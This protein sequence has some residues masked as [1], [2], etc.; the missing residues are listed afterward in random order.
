MVDATYQAK[1][2]MTDGGDKQVIASGGELDVESGG[3]FKIA[4]TAVTAS[5]AELNGDSAKVT[6]FTMAAASAAAN[7]SEVTITAKDAAGATLAGVHNFDLW[8]SDAATGA[9]LTGTAASGTVTAKSAS[10]EVVGTY[11]AKKALRVQTLATGI[12]ILE[13][14]D[15]GKTAYKVAAAAPGTGKTVVGITLETGD[16]GA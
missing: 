13:I 16:Y 6:T 11:T 1:V 15:T 12:F 3:A 5:A 8:L 14:T 10:G 9:G 4:G 7:V 2:Y